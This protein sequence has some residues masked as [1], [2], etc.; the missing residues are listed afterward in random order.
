MARRAPAGPPQGQ[1]PALT[2]GQRRRRRRLDPSTGEVLPTWDQALDAIAKDDE[3]FHV[4]RFGERFD[5]QGVLAGSKDAA[6]CISYLT[7]YLTKQV[8]NCHQLET[9]AQRQHA[10]RLAEE[11][12]YQPCSACCANWLRYG[13][14]PKNARPGLVP[15]AASAR[16]MTP[17]TSATPDGECW[18]PASG[19]ARRWL[20]TGPTVRPG[21]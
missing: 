21:C 2:P 10:A 12:R 4:A 19:P 1:R 20:T 14:Q 11:L 3:P 9:D 13:I 18:C 7:K 5:A 6:R 8:G 16:R 15:A 17:I